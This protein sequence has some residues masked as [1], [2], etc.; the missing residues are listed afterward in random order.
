[1]REDGLPV[2]QNALD[3]PREYLY[4]LNTNDLYA[5]EF[6]GTPVPQGQGG[7]R[8]ERIGHSLLIER[9]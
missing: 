5:N 6:A 3:K 8:R 9:G 7:H 1:M 2:H 4:S